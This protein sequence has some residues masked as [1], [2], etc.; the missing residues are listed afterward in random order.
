[1]CTQYTPKFIARFWSKVDKSGGPHACW[2]WTRSCARGYGRVCRGGKMVGAHRVAYE[3]AN[4]GIK[5]G[6]DVC[7]TCDN[8]RCVNPSHL[9]EGTCIE[10][11][12]DAVAKGRAARGDRSG[13]RLHPE[14]MQ[15]GDQ[16]YTRRHP[17][18]VTR[19]EHHGRAKLTEPK[20]REIRLR[21][22]SGGSSHRALAKEY[23][24]GRSV[25]SGIVRGE[26]W[27]HVT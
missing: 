8:P 20:V 11:I 15:R 18:A 24:V 6:M 4:R 17:E 21:Y 1:M 27:A 12:R 13:P 2:L 19:G 9:W 7:H 22:A 10:N 14:A 16:H 26:D 5:P 3:L 23:G 25:I